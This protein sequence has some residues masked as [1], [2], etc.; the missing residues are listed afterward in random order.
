LG[1]TN[2]FERM[3]ETGDAIGELQEV[4]AGDEPI[5]TV[6]DRMV[7][8]VLRVVPDADEVSVTVLTDGEPSTAAA[9][10][11]RVIAIDDDQYAAGNGPCLEAARTRE[12]LLVRGAEAFGRW[13]RFAAAAERAGVHAY[14]SAPLVM[15]DGSDELIGALNVYAD[16]E[17]AF[18]ALDKALLSLLTIAAS[19]AISHSRRYLRVQQLADRLRQ[20]LGSRAEID[21]ATGVLMAVHGVPADKALG[22]LI[23]KSQQTGANLRQVAADLLAS[24]RDT[25]RD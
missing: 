22:R 23:E 11:D 10:D 7:E 8:L 16:R 15:D 19:A 24:M 3:D 9:S 13:P 5:Q 12:P 18:D 1:V 21:Q 17:D 4:L 20:A 6:L 25:I 14:L 2:E